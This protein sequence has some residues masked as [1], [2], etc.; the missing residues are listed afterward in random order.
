MSSYP[1][2]LGQGELNFES[3]LPVVAVSARG[4]NASTGK[5]AIHEGSTN[6]IVKQSRQSVVCGTIYLR[7]LNKL[8]VRFVC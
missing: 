7:D 5:T 3:E 1:I 6:S 4:K 8:C 2:Y